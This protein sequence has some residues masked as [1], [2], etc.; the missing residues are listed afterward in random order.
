MSSLRS[1]ASRFGFGAAGAASAFEKV[2]HKVEEVEGLLVPGQ[3][4]WLFQAARSL[5]NGARILEIG[6]YLGRSSISLGYGC[7]GSRRHVFAVDTFGGTYQ[8]LLGHEELSRVFKEGFLHRWQANVRKNGLEE[9][10]TPLVGRSE[11]IARIWAAPINMLFIDGSHQFEDVVRD[12]EDFFPHVVPGGIVAL[13]D[14][15]PS[16]NGCERAWHNHVKHRLTDVGCVSTLAYGRKAE[17]QS[18]E[19]NGA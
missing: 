4:K 16:W 11:T 10:V 2:R 3:E 8:D 1:L 6:S 7:R 15:T 5:P 18:C 9:W 17:S 13:H 14:V 12:F 19:V